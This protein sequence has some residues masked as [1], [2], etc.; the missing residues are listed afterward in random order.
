MRNYLT[1]FFRNLARERLYAAINIV[2][3]ALGLASCLIL[4]LFL[5]GELTYDRHLE[6]PNRCTASPTSSSPAARASAS[7]PPPKRWAR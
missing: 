5:R 1:L 4:G 6:G 7:P 3:L 2:G